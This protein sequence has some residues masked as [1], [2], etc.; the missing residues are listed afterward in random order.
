MGRSAMISFQDWLDAMVACPDCKK[1]ARA[2]QLPGKLL[3]MR[4]V[5][6]THGSMKVQPPEEIPHDPQYCECGARIADPRAIH[7]CG[8]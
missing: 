3:V 6:H 2:Y 4:E 7:L 1:D 8:R 5:C